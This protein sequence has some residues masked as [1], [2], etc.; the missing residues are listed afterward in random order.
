[1][2]YL[3]SRLYANIMLDDRIARVERT[4]R[5]YK[6]LPFELDPR[7]TVEM[8]VRTLVLN[9]EM[10]IAEVSQFVDVFKIDVAY[11]W[12]ENGKNIRLSR[13]AYISDHVNSQNSSP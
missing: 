10:N 5:A 11:N 12:V 13:S 1:M 7:E 3:N 9:P 8:G 4:L 6:V 2:S